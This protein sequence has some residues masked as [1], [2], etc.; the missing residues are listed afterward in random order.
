MRLAK[1][2]GLCFI[3][4]ICLVTTK[5]VSKKTSNTK[6]NGAYQL[7]DFMK[8]KSKLLPINHNRLKFEYIIIN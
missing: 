4:F 8:I 3:R 7:F 1:K 5:N 2:E 6:V